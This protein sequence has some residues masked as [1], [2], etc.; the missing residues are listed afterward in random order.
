MTYTAAEILSSVSAHLVTPQAIA[1]VDFA[2]EFN[3]TERAANMARVVVAKGY[4]PAEMTEANDLLS[5]S[6][7]VDVT[8][9]AIFIV[10]DVSVRAHYA[11]DRHT[12]FYGPVVTMPRAA[13]TE[14][15]VDM[16]RALSVR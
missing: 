6:Y 13:G 12:M 4:V 11:R 15:A 1:L 7:S 9:D 10:K 3:G 8:D 16:I 14:L 5:V 2:R